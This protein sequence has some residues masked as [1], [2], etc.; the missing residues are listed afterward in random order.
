MRLLKFIAYSPL[1]LLVCAL[2]GAVVGWFLPMTSSATF[3]VGQL[4]M[5]FIYLAAFPLLV[6]IT[7]FGIKR[8][9]LL[10]K[11]LSRFLM[12]AV[13]G[14]AI[15]AVCAVVGALLSGMLGLG[16]QL[17][18]E[19]L[20]YLGGVV[21][22]AGGETVD[23]RI[24]F[25][26]KEAPQPQDV[27]FGSGVLPQNFFKVLTDGQILGILI[28]S[29]ILGAGVAWVDKK[30]SAALMDILDGIYR[31]LE[32]IV[33]QV[34]LFIPVLVFAMSA[35][36]AATATPEALY[37]MGGFIA[38]FVGFSLL[39]SALAV[40]FIWKKTKLTLPEV[41]IALKNPMLISL[42]SANPTASIPD[43]IHAMSS[44]LGFSRGIVEFVV[45]A[46][47]VFVRSGA[48][49]YFAALAVFVG[50]LYGQSLT[51]ESLGLIALMA[52]F[53]AFTSAGHSGIAVVGFAA[54]MLHALKL[55]VEAAIALFMAIDHLCEGP[56]SLLSLM[57][58]CVLIVLVSQGLPSERIE[59][60]GKDASMHATVRLTLTSHSMLLASA[61]VLAVMVLIVLL[62]VGVGMR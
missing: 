54:V 28:C 50:N 19:K 12:M 29:M 51:L 61:C 30:K 5:A 59:Q 21:Q 24:E 25:F 15:V 52:T 2:A 38:F 32:I 13:Y 26:G 3:L 39:I 6:V 8:T 18:P 49:L 35:Y 31:T 1:A 11:P 34:N 41:L 53:A 42:A 40:V 9:L 7:V 14:I 55:P 56:R 36:F 16:T 4:Y 62:G 44:R 22:A 17:E 27:S 58:G 46:S 60:Q 23:A 10:P 48:A 43:T 20:R 47:S 37:A 57:L 45:P 33:A